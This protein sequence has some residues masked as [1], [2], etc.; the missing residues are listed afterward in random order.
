MTGI[1]GLP[2][3]DMVDQGSQLFYVED[4]SGNVVG[5]FEALKTTT[6]DLAGS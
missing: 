1:N 6:S 3:D 2:P 4:P 5:S